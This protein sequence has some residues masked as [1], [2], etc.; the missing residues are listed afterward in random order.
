VGKEFRSVG[1]LELGSYP[2][3]STEE[4]DPE[5]LQ[6]QPLSSAGGGPAKELVLTLIHELPRRGIFPETGLPAWLCN[7]SLGAIPRRRSR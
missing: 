5:G 3:E 1:N 6:G 2:L 7:A 4:L